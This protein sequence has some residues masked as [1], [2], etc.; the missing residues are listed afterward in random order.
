MRAVTV[1]WEVGAAWAR[2]QRVAVRRTR[3][4]LEEVQHLNAE[5]REDAAGYIVRHRYQ[6]KQLGPEGCRRAV[7]QHNV[8]W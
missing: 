5:H 6:A 8:E 1:E 2:R 7:V 3:E 4:E